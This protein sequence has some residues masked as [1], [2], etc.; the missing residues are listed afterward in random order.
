MFDFRTALKRYESYR[1]HKRTRE[2]LERLPAH[3]QNDVGY[4]HRL[5]NMR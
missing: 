5:R 1:A 4:P 2:I 3:L